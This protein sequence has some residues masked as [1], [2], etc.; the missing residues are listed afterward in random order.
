MTA[1][2]HRSLEIYLHRIL[3]QQQHQQGLQKQVVEE[4]EE[5]KSNIHYVNIEEEFTLKMARR[6][7]Q[8]NNIDD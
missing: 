1:M 4:E 7:N 6:T 2:V 8:P 3:L 5:A